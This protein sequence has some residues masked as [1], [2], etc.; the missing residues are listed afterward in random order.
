MAMPGSRAEG[1]SPLFKKRARAKMR[2]ENWNPNQFDAEIE[3][4]AI[5]RLV[6][7]AEVVKVQAQRL[8]PVGTITR[9]IYKSGPYAGLEWTRRDAGALKKTIRVV[10]KQSKSGRPL[11]RKRNVRVYA[12]NWLVYYASIVEY[13][14]KAFMRPALTAAHADMMSIIKEG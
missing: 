12:G 7:A 10:Q 5:E 2:V 1:F 11:M 13:T 8:V 9:P 14:G 4:V 3:N 6:K